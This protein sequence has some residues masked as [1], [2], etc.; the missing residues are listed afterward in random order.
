[1]GSILFAKVQLDP[2]T[3]RKMSCQRSSSGLESCLPVKIERNGIRPNVGAENGLELVISDETGIVPNN[4]VHKLLYV[5]KTN[6]V[7]VKILESHPVICVRPLQKC[8][9]HRKVGP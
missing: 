8:L 6:D 2:V 1:M 5:G 7:H 3:G 9:E 4:E